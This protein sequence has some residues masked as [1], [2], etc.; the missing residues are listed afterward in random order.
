VKV[1][2]RSSSVILLF[3]FLCCSESEADDKVSWF[4]EQALFCTVLLE[5]V[6]GDSIVPHGTG[7]L[8]YN[9]EIEGRPIVVTCAHVLK[10]REIYVSVTADS[11]FIAY[12]EK[13]TKDK[14]SYTLT[15]DGCNWELIKGKLR[16]RVKLDKDLTF[17]THPSLD[18]AVRM[19]K[20]TVKDVLRLLK[21]AFKELLE[22]ANIP[23]YSEKQEAHLKTSQ[24]L[25][26]QRKKL[27]Y[28]VYSVAIERI[29][30]KEVRR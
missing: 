21:K 18:I 2:N 17:V 27:L 23:D 3:L 29:T 16:C 28:G 5:K 14:G 10:G 7:F 9:Y 11:E 12:I 20:L 25:Y 24:K 1:D 6:D 22:V 8:A 19:Y 30:T 26:E 13:K 15:L 4:D